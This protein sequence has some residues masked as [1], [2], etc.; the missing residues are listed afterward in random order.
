MHCFYRK[1]RETEHLKSTQLK[2]NLLPSF[3]ILSLSVLQYSLMNE[4]IICIKYMSFSKN[5]VDT[6]YC[7][8]HNLFIVTLKNFRVTE[9]NFSSFVLDFGQLSEK[10]TK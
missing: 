7:Q 8:L 10:S 5:Q 2:L 9:F 3:E 4:L 6:K 1:E